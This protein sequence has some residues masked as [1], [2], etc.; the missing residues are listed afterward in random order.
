MSLLLIILGILFSF[1]YLI[2]VGKLL[3]SLICIHHLLVFRY[4]PFRIK[5]GLPHTDKAGIAHQ[6]LQFLRIY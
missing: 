1:R 4:S 6:L 3:I 5:S 2:F